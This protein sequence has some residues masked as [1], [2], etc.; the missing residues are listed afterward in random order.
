MNHQINLIDYE[1]GINLSSIERLTNKN[2]LN[3]SI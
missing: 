3:W 1:L 2:V